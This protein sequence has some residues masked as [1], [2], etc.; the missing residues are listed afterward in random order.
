MKPDL[1]VYGQIEGLTPEGWNDPELAGLREGLWL[2]RLDYDPLRATVDI[3]HEGRNLTDADE[4]SA[5]LQRAADLLPEGGRGHA[6]HIDNDAWV[7]TRFTLAPG[8]VV[9]KTLP[10]DAVLDGLELTQ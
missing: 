8:K 2:D 7:L 3:E 9:R 4:L 5:F 1:R 6:E 10:I